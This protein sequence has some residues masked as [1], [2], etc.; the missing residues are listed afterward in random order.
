[1]PLRAYHPSF[2]EGSIESLRAQ[3][4]PRWRLLIIDDGAKP[5]PIVR[6]ALADA[7]VTL[8]R[9]EGRRLAGA[10][11]TGMRHAKTDFVASL[12]ADDMWAPEAVRV[13]TEHIE[14]EPGVDFLHSGRVFIDEHGERIS[15]AYR[16]PD[17]VAPADFAGGSPVKHLLCWRR[18]RGLSIGGIDESINSVG[19]DDWDF[20][21]RM[22]EHGAVFR[23]VPEP[24]Y[25]F[26]DHRECERLTTHLPLSVHKREM[27]RI[28]KKH[29]VP[30]SHI[31]RHIAAAERN[32][33]RQCVY[34]SRLDRWIKTARGYDPRRGWR[35]H[36]RQPEA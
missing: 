20:P 34:R 8:V 12:F 10:L 35:E 19:P 30:R 2:L 5:T 31:E 13:L 4:S 26:R 11:N 1:M 15:A 14:A 25:L 17:A 7:R 18:E 9:N 33:L 22:A 27:R 21:W 16:N 32:F 23:A 36:Y 6:E 29:G 3:T 24:L 28:M